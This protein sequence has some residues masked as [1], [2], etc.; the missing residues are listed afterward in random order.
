MQ[1]NNW[2]NNKWH[3][4][5]S[6]PAVLCD[7]GCDVTCQA[8]RENSPRTSSRYRARFQ[9]SSGHSDSANWPVYEAG[10][11]QVFSHTSRLES[12]LYSLRSC[13]VNMLTHNVSLPAMGELARKVLDIQPWILS[14]RYRRMYFF[15]PSLWRQCNLHQQWWILHLYL[16]EWIFWWRENL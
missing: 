11:N 7:F 4:P 13:P 3:N 12:E 2:S 8:C 10:I 9:T 15:C 5:A 14:F 6:F 1:K 16:Q